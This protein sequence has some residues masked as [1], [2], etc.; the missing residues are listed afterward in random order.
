MSLF[1]MPFQLSNISSERERAGLG[2]WLWVCASQR[3]LIPTTASRVST[4][5]ESADRFICLW[6]LVMICF[7]T[8]FGLDGG[9]LPRFGPNFGSK[10]KSGAFEKINHRRLKIVGS[11]VLCFSQGL[12]SRTMSLIPRTSRK[13]TCQE[14]TWYLSLAVPSHSI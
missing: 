6:L 7:R 13:A 1:P 5:S 10:D 11:I 14:E 8:L 12:D 3:R 2:G 4:D 9:L